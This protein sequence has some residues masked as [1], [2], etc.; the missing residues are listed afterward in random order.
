[1]T[2][3]QGKSNSVYFFRM[4]IRVLMNLEFDMIHAASATNWNW[5][6][7]SDAVSGPAAW[8]YYFPLCGAGRFQSPINI[9]SRHLIFDHQLTSISINNSDHVCLFVSY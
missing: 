4:Q 3:S 6:D 1:M 5:W 9:E 7:Y 8:G 2:I